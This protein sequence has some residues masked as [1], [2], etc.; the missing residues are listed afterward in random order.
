MFKVTYRCYGGCM[1]FVGFAGSPIQFSIVMKQMQY[2]SLRNHS[3]VLHF[4]L[5]Y[6]VILY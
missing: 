2:L 6:M 4:H 5:K 3:K 1:A